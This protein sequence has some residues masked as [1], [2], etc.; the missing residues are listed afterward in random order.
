LLV[1]FVSSVEAQLDRAQWSDDVETLTASPHRLTGTPEA[2]AAGDHLVQRLRTLGVPR[3]LEQTFDVVPIAARGSATLRVGDESVEVWPLRPSVI[4]PSGVGVPIAGRIVDRRS[5]NASRGG[6]N[7]SGGAIVLLDYGD[8]SGWEAAFTR[9]AAAVVFVGDGSTPV[10]AKHAAVPINLPRFYAESLPRQIGAGATATLEPTAGSIAGPRR[11]ATGRNVAAVFPGT[12]ADGEAVVVAVA[13]DSFGV[14]PRRSPAARRAGNVAALLQLAERLVASPPRRDVW[15]VFFDNRQQRHRGARAFY[16]ALTIDRENHDR[17]TKQH[18]DEAAQVR[19][20]L[21]QLDAWVADSGSAT[22]LT[23]ASIDALRQR[24]D[25]SRADLDR[26]RQNLRRAETGDEAS[27]DIERLQDQVAA[28]DRVRRWLNNGASLDARPTEDA[29]TVDRLLERTTLDLRRRAAEL[30]TLVE[31]DAQRAAL[32]EALT[33]NGERAR[34]LLHLD[35]DLSDG[36]ATW[37]PIAGGDGHRL[38]G[39]ATPRPEADAPGF[40]ARLLSG[41]D[42]L[43]DDAPADRYPRLD[44]E[45]LRNPAYAEAFVPGPFTPSG[46]VAGGFGLYHL[47]LMTGHDARPRDG[48][49]ADTLEQLDLDRLLPQLDEA[50]T[51]LQETIDTP[52]IRQAASFVSQIYSN[53]PG[54]DGR[55]PTGP[56]ATLRVTGG[57][58]ENRPADDAVIG[59]WPGRRSDAN[60]SWNAL[61]EPAPADFSRIDVT[62]VDANG[63]FAVVGLRRDLDAELTTFGVRFDEHGQVVAATTQ[64]TLNQGIDTALRVDLFTGRGYGLLWPGLYPSDGRPFS[65]LRARSDASYRDN[66]SLKGR[67]GK[68][69]FWYLAERAVE[70][71]VKLFDPLGAVALGMSS[72]PQDSAFHRSGDAD[73]SGGGEPSG[74]GRAMDEA[75]GVELSRFA[76]PAAW[77][78]QTARDLWQLNEGRLA[79]LRA[80]GVTAADL[81]LLHARAGRELP[82]GSADG[83]TADPSPAAAWRSTALSQKVYPRLRATMDDLVHAIVVLLLLTIPFSFAVER[84]L[85]GATSVYGRIAGFTGVFLVTFG[86]I[87]ATHPGFAIASTPVMIFL[88]FAI[89]LLSILVIWLLVRRFQT[90]LREMQGVADFRDGAAATGAAMAAI[91]MGMSTMRRRPTRTLLTTITVVMLTFTV[92]CFASVQRGVGVRAVS[93]GPVSEAMP[94][95]AVLVRAV[96]GGALPDGVA[97]VLPS[98]AGTWLAGWWR[99]AEAGGQRPITVARLDDGRSVRLGAVLGMDEQTAAAWPAW[100]EALPQGLRN[101]DAREGEAPAEPG[102]GETS[103]LGGSLALPAS[104]AAK[105]DLSPGDRVLLDGRPVRYVGPTD[106]RVLTTLRQPDGQPVLPV[107]R[108][109]EAALRG[110]QGPSGGGGGEAAGAGE[111]LRLSADRVALASNATVR[112]LGGDLHTYTLIADE[113]A[114]PA[115]V[116]AELAELLPTPVWVAGPAGTQRLTLGPITRVSGLLQL[117]APVILGGLIIFGTLLGSISDR[118]REIYTF[119]ALGLGPRHVGLLFFAEAAVYAAVGGLGGQLLAQVVALAASWLVDLGWMRPV[120]IN[121]ASTQALFAIAVVMATVLVSAIYPALRAS[122]SANPGLARAWT[123]PAPEDPPHDDQLNLTFPFTVSAYDLTGVVAFLAEHFRQH[124][125]AGLGPFAASDVALGRD[126]EGRLQLTTELALAPF[127][128][129]VTE[130]FRLTGVPSD[131]PG[132]DEVR[133][134]LRRNS[135]AKGDWLRANRVFLKALRRRF[136]IWRTLPPARV[137]D[138]RMQ[139]LQTLGER[140]TEPAGAA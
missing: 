47:A 44:R 1:C 19:S 120:S 51:F 106:G 82:P 94:T 27:P 83:T 29:D 109:A 3:V 112:Q 5:D 66:L 92:L 69:L 107:D 15:L 103:R 80:R 84:L 63:R 56:F 13:Y 24:A 22:E 131:I 132:V 117:L 43:A 42:R 89:L 52:S 72:P 121:F 108:E 23:G 64:A 77:V 115:A 14:V 40:H 133:V 26:Q 118:Q 73:S 32:H 7:A 58:S 30:D 46:E 134:E 50:L 39:L 110:S 129:G 99:V 100:G 97:D 71:R 81:E 98:Q 123:M 88:A 111:V 116:G 38:Y 9:G 6:M 90:E 60:A 127:D 122:R 21:D 54:W 20:I 139:T 68:G 119:S 31:R 87:Y 49:P 78:T 124:A 16:D 137:E 101:L 8:E 91:G 85:I 93:L 70:P 95:R 136:L 104:A 53:H 55:R 138:Y 76:Q 61:T 79:R 105:L 135:G 36:G 125:D 102:V 28:W 37:A 140:E 48:H 17:Q 11:I 74:G 128:L 33:D 62:P 45:T 41:L 114:D 126:D 2:A 18:A 34:I 25:W 59:L 57:L 75:A 65:V 86:L 4:V 113:A 130:S 96:D 12:G 10:E 67:G 35:L